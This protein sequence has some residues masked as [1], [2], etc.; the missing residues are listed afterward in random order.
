MLL[1]LL[2]GAGKARRM[3][4]RVP[5]KLGLGCVHDIGKLGCVHD[6]GKL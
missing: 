1:S 5:P 4:E 6:I 3:H 2:A